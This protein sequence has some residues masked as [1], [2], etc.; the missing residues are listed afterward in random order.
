M[1]SVTVKVDGK[2]RIIIPKEI[3]ETVNIREGSYLAIR[4]KEKTI[5]MN[6]LYSSLCDEHITLP[7]DQHF[8]EKH[9]VFS[10]IDRV[11]YTQDYARQL[12][13]MVKTAVRRI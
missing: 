8:P 13:N 3:R 9:T 12:A 1:G 11:H 4:A 6:K 2:G 5:M 10:G 7:M